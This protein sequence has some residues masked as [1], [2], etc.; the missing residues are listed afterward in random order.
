MFLRRNSSRPG[1]I[2]VLTTLTLIIFLT[3]VA[4]AFD[5]GLLM[6]ARNQ[7]QVAADVAAMAGTR[8][9]TGDTSTNNNYDQVVPNAKKAAKANSILGKPI[10]DSQL[11][12]TIG[13]YYYDDPSKSWTHVPSRHLDDYRDLLEE[14]FPEPLPF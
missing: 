4:L 9:L 5:L 13:D 12:L 3:F 10:D 6:L 2:V 7:S 14:W 1:T 8:T 11:T